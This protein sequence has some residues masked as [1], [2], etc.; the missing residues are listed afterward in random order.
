MN[1]T[2]LAS[3]VLMSITPAAISAEQH[4]EEVIITASAHAK[5]AAELA[6]SINLI[7]DEELQRA[8]AANLGD[9]LQNQVGI[10]SSSFGS[11]VGLPM[12]RG[13]SGK[14]IEVLQ[15]AAVVADASDASPDHAN[16]SEALLADRIEI[17]R[18]PATLRFGPGAI[19][20][21]INVVDSR[22]HREPHSG[23]VGALEMRHGSVN[24]ESSLVG[25]L[26]AGNGPLAL[27][28]SGVH[29]DSNNTDIP[30]LADRR[31]DDADETTRGYIENTSAQSS[32]ATL[33]ISRV[34]EQLVVGLA[35]SFLDNNYGIP[36]G[37]HGGHAHGEETAD[38][39]P[40]EAAEA[41][42][43]VT[44]VDMQ[45][46]GWQGKLLYNFNSAALEQLDIDLSYSQYLH[47][48]LEQELGESHRASTFD[49]DSLELRG[50]LTHNIVD[51]RGA[52]GFQYSQRDSDISGEEAFLPDSENDNIGLYWMGETDLGE[53][54]L[55]FGL[56]ADH[57]QVDSSNFSRSHNSFNSSASLLRPLDE[58]QR[59]SL[60][61]SRTE[62][63]PAAE[64]LLSNGRHVATST[65]EIGNPALDT[66]SALNAELGWSREGTLSLRASLFHNAFSD[67]IYE[68]S[69]G[70]RFSHD[71]EAEGLSGRAVCSVALAD[72]ENN[73]E[74]FD[75][76]LPCFVFAQEDA[77]FTGIEL[78]AEYQLNDN[79]SLRLQG[80]AVR[81][82]LDHS[83]D[84]P[85]MPPARFGLS[86]NYSDE[87]WHL[88]LGATHSFKQSRPGEN[89][90]ATDSFT[91]IQG[92][93]T[94][95]SENWML[96]L[97]GQNLADR[98]IRNAASFLRH[99]AP[100]PGRNLTLG[101]RYQFN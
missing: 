101:V 7:T 45:Q 75:E 18:G 20:G 22:I 52:A 12:I 37:G 62:R 78:E 26:D 29:R 79:H 43:A 27:H 71:L 32:A 65:Y 80:D 85:R 57:Q 17:L 14:R 46:R 15:N 96:F 35:Y 76:A 56:R 97:R 73:Q 31:V 72:F 41:A 70:S 61:V 9:T 5:S 100:E 64:E 93:I 34:G 2:L 90:L 36:A 67:F 16:A 66:E 1:K 87:S 11:G 33:G 84:V 91:R 82:R 68:S 89:E 39:A 88:E 40:A 44:R 92:S 53:S 69:D 60:V 74:E 48:E 23:T 98:D 99:V 28:L 30:G 24:D 19:G 42:E 21:V 10:N 59:I 47:H 49:I 38:S 86:W 8:A 55:E 13:Q 54:T 95:H 3:A 83:G 4:L 58:Q 51:W 50:E 63:A 25:R 6:G 77:R 81:A 94:W